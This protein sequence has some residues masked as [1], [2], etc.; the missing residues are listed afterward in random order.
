MST[1]NASRY[2]GLFS[3]GVKWTENYRGYVVQVSSDP[4]N[5]YA[6]SFEGA[7]KWLSE[8]TK[9]ET[10]SAL[11]KHSETNPWTPTYRVPAYSY[12]CTAYVRTTLRRALELHS[13]QNVWADTKYVNAANAL[14]GRHTWADF[15]PDKTTWNLTKTELMTI[16][17]AITWRKAK[18]FAGLVDRGVTSTQT[19]E[20]AHIEDEIYRV[21]R[22]IWHAEGKYWM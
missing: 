20:W 13:T 2:D 16:H 19:Q 12:T 17:S 15:L 5:W 7:H 18:R 1:W 21:L 8:G 22:G 3:L 9:E 6:Y 4:E 10:M 14:V 11:E